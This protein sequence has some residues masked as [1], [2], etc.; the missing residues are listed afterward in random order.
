[1]EFTYTDE[2]D[3]I[4]VM[5]NIDGVHFSSIVDKES[6]KVVDIFT[7]NNGRYGAINPYNENTSLKNITW[8]PVTYFEVE[9]AIEDFFANEY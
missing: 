7:L 1:M 8:L 3:Y 2:L 6:K 5:F 4:L 9:K